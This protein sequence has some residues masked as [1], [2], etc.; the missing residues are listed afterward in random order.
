KPPLSKWGRFR[1]SGNFQL[2]HLLYKI[3]VRRAIPENPS[4]MAGRTFAQGCG[5][6]GI[7]KK[8]ERSKALLRTKFEGRGFHTNR[9]SPSPVTGGGGYLSDSSTR[10]P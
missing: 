7:G 5:S 8:K 3:Q 2:V 4:C 1:S 9:A 6:R 10:T